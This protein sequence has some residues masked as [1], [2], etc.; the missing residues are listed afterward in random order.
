MLVNG[1]SASYYVYC[2]SGLVKA[3]DDVENGNC[4]IDK[5]YTCVD[6]VEADENI[7]VTQ[8][9]LENNTGLIGIYQKIYV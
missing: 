4:R 5:D 6:I 3:V 8:E 1:T 9:M 7:Y 2:G